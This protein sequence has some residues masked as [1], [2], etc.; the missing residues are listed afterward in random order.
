MSSTLTSH[1]R[2]LVELC[3]GGIEDVLLAARLH[4]DRIEL[5]SGMAVGG[6]TPPIGLV[7]AARTAFSEPIVSMVRPREGGFCYTA[8]EFR[9]M[10]GDCES[11]LA[12]GIEGAAT[13]FLKADG[14]IDTERCLELRRLFPDATLVFH[15]AFD[16]TPDLKLALQQIID[17]G[18]NR[19]LTSGG[20][21]AAIEGV[22]Q[23]RM[24]RQLAREQIEILPGGGIRAGNVGQ[25]VLQTECNQFHSAAREI[26]EDSSTQH[27]DAFQFGLA[28]CSS[29]AF[30]RASEAQLNALLHAVTEI[31][32]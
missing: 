19:I 26:A 3:A 8:A 10:L 17:C 27:N 20:K 13:G 24:L 21:P 25:L 14:T 6:L 23:L 5:N 22:D 16:V 32:P 30:G 29:G 18:F 12:A 28:G 11:I 2:V 4:V 9:Q 31:K 15:K 7:N 1:R